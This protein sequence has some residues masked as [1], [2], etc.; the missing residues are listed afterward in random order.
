MSNSNELYH[1]GVLGMKWGVR[2]YQNRDGS[3]TK[4]GK[5]HKEAALKGLRDGKEEYLDI[6]KEM[7]EYNQM[8]KQL[9]KESKAKDAKTGEISWDT[10]VLTDTYKSTGRAYVDA[11]YKAHTYDAYIKAYDRDTIKAGEDYVMKNFKTGV[12]TLTDSGREKEKK[13]VDR[14]H[15]DIN[16][17]Y[18]KEIKKY[19]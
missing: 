18:A 15:D 2:R 11:M 3:L 1:Y 5:K 6:A 4:L 17:R 14:V 12:V 9:L 7:K 13:I 10:Q 19:S 8:S 16:R